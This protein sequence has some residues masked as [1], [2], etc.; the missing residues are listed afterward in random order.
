MKGVASAAMEPYHRVRCGTQR[1][2]GARIGL[3]WHGTQWTV[4]AC[5]VVAGKP[6]LCATTQAPSLIICHLCHGMEKP[7][8]ASGC[9]HL[10]FRGCS[11]APLTDI[12]LLMHYSLA[13]VW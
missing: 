13:H 7:G 10:S 11:Q 2:D 12:G 9:A 8:Q 6:W 4:Y 3:D 5:P 1:T